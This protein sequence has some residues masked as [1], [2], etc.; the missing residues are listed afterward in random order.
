MLIQSFAAGSCC[1][2]VAVWSFS[3]LENDIEVVGHVTAL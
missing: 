3:E 2:V 1:L